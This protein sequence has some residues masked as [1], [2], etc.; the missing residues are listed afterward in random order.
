[1]SDEFPAVS[2]IVPGWGVGAYLGEALASLQAQTRADWEAIVVDDGDTERVAAAVAPFAADPRIR[3]LATDHAGLAAARNRGIATARAPRIALLDGDDRY[4]PD[5]LERMIERLD[6]DPATGFVTCDAILFGVPA[7]EGK[8]FS[9]LEPQVGPVTLERVIRRDF[10]VFGAATIRRAALAAV[11]GYDESLLSAEDLDLWIRLLAEGWGGVLL[12]V[13]LYEYRRRAASLS[14]SSASLARWVRQVYLNAVGRLEG[15]PELQAARDMLAEADND[16]AI[17]EAMAAILEGRSREGIGR[18][19]GTDIGR[20]S[21][22]WRVA[23]TAFSL[24]PPLARPV[25]RFYM[26]RQP[27]GSTKAASC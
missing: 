2:V 21:I 12:A 19:R 5:Y 16:L 10:K 9:E 20:R 11:G 26:R 3:L 17:S 13:P 24:F 6:T 4:R 14:A 1:M 8:R 18:L 22:K 25:L 23:L 27:F 7:F 15:R